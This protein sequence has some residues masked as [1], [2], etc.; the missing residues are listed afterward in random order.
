MGESVTVLA[1][2]IKLLSLNRE[3][4]GTY[5]QYHVDFEPDVEIEK[6]RRGLLKSALPNV[7]KLV[8]RGAEFFTKTAILNAD[9]TVSSL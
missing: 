1:N 2:Y 7:G 6:V 5:D 3:E 8:F 9:E 4:S